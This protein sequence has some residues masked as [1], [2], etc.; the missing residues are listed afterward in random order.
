MS[1][2]NSLNNMA[3][4]YNRT[5]VRLKWYGLPI[6]VVQA[7]DLSRKVILMMHTDFWDYPLG[8]KL[9]SVDISYNENKDAAI[10]SRYL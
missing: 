8:F 10:K 5:I 6:N 3:Y 2:S 9:K 1:V 7:S 4:D